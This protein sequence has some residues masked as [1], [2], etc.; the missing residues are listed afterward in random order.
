VNLW[1]LGNKVVFCALKDR[2]YKMPLLLTIFAN[3]W[4]VYTGGNNLIKEVTQS[5]LVIKFMS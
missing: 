5:E 1:P 3:N 4:G 2:G